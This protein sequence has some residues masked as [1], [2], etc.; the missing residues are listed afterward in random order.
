MMSL[1]TLI[2]FGAFDSTGADFTAWCLE[3]GFRRCGILPLD[4]CA[5]AAIAHK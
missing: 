1:N 5:S 4:G 3:A 2:E